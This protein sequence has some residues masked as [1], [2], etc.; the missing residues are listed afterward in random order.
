MIT[1]SS[2]CVRT[3]DTTRTCFIEPD[4]ADAPV[5]PFNASLSGSTSIWLNMST[6]SANTGW[7]KTIQTP[8][9]RRPGLGKKGYL[10]IRSLK[11]HM[12]EEENSFLLLAHLY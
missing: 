3:N 9:D 2:W 12:H 11:I 7:E 4:R 6:M 8:D 1:S 5:H 10:D